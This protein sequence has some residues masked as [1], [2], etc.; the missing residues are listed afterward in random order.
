ML[1]A[2]YWGVKYEISKF[3]GLLHQY[4]KYDKRSQTAFFENVSLSTRGR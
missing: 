4:T 1:W 2:V 3:S